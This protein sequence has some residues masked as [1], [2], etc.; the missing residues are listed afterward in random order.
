MYVQYYVR[1]WEDRESLDIVK[2]LKFSNLI[3]NPRD[4]YRKKIRSGII[5][6]VPN[7]CTNNKC[8]I[9]LW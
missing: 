7:M 6:Y 5:C 2:N 8:Y 4:T 3:G 1:W 9:Q